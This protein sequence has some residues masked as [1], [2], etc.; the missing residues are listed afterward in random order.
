MSTRMLLPCLVGVALCAS[1]ICF[2]QAKLPADT[3]A[4]QV[5]AAWLDAFN[6]GDRGTYRAFLE[7]Y[8]RSRLDRPD[9]AVMVYG[10]RLRFAG[11]YGEP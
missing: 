8:S 4:G 1:T 10:G 7:K 3:P 11:P 5:C 9:T 6:S 2:G